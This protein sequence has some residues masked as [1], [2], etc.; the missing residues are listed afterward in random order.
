MGA[1]VQITEPKPA[2]FDGQEGI[3][4]TN[5]DRSLDTVLKGHTYRDN[6][7]LCVMPSPSE[8]FDHRV[9]QSM[10]TL[11]KPMNQ[12]FSRWTVA[13]CEVAD[14]YNKG[15]QAILDNE[16]TK[17]WKFVLCWEHD[18]LPP[19]D[20][21]LKLQAAMWDGPWAGVGG[22]YWTKGPGGQPMCY[23]QPGTGNYVPFLPALDSVQ[24][25]NGIAQ[26]FSLFDL[27]LFRRMKGPWFKTYQEWSPE[28]GIKTGTQD[29]SF[30][31]RARVECGARFAVHAGVRVGH[32][33]L[34]GPQKGFVW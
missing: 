5:W 22:L 31:E 10:E 25:C 28:G 12:R 32:M 9:V 8:N 2:M 16:T 14:A 26:G 15:V 3:R 17:N 11:I 33:E 7:T 24:E 27:E 4:N 18:N 21:L 29:L 1:V 23:G 13:G 34:S 19:P 30:C 6:S 20:G